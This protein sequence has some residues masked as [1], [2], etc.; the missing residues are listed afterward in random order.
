LVYSLQLATIRPKSAAA[1]CVAEFLAH[2]L[3]SSSQLKSEYYL[4]D[5]NF[6]LATAKKNLSFGGRSFVELFDKLHFQPWERWLMRRPLSA[7]FSSFLLLAI[8]SPSRYYPQI[9]WTF[10]KR[11]IS[12]TPMMD[13]LEWNPEGEINQS[14][15][16]IASFLWFSSA[17]SLP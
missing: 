3:P 9:F 15:L 8:V 14:A 7:S 5:E 17:R 1:V 10:R 2:L 11:L 4:C 6:W 13:G 16:T 12:A